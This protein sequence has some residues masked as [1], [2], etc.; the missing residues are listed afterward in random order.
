MICA[1]NYSIAN[2]DEYNAK[3]QRIYKARLAKIESP[4]AQEDWM[5]KQIMK[6][7]RLNGSR[8]MK[9][10]EEGKGKKHVK[11]AQEFLARYVRCD[12]IV[13]GTV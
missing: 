3:I 8:V 9:E 11:K 1:A 7:N 12:I 2:A 4:E 10:L 6:F 5:F 13:S